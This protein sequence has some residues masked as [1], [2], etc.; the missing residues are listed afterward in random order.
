MPITGPLVFLD[1][2]TTGLDP[3]TDHI[4]EI[5][6][7]IVADGAVTE[8]QM[9]VEHDVDLVAALPDAY[10]RDHATRYDPTAAVSA[11]DAARTVREWFTGRRHLAGANPA[12]DAAMLAHLMHHTGVGQPPWHHHLIDVETLAVAY[13]SSRGHRIDLPWRSDDLAAATG[14]PMT[15]PD[16]QPRYARHTALDDARWTRD[17]YVHLEHTPA[18]TA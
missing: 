12:Y 2:E 8:Y 11:A 15:L 14:L 4:W 7:V 16:G 1:T 6:A 9:F 3:F 17:W 18:A 13:L 10:R 5:A